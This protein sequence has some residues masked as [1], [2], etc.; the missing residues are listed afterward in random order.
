MKENN[1]Y[2]WVRAA[3]KESGMKEAKRISQAAHLLFKGRKRTVTNQQTPKQDVLGVI[4]KR[5]TAFGES[6]KEMTAEREKRL[7]ND[8][9][10]KAARLAQRK[11]EQKFKERNTGI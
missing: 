10:E 11:S 9:D 6:L 7:K 1:K 2:R 4:G 8:K 5:V 3:I